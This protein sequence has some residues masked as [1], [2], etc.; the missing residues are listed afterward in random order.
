M[1]SVAMGDESLGEKAAA[2]R[3]QMVHGS[4]ALANLLV[5]LWQRKG[6]AHEMIIPVDEVA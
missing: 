4:I 6:R 1:A 2:W 5:S 3:W